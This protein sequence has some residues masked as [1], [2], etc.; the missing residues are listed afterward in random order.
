[1]YG[2]CIDYHNGGDCGQILNNTI[3]LF[4]DNTTMNVKLICEAI[5]EQDIILT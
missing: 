5:R 3:Y 1:M 2:Q 4:S